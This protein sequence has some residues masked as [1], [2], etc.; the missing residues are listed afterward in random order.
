[1]VSIVGL[2]PPFVVKKIL[3][4]KSLR[5]RKSKKR[6]LRDKRSQSTVIIYV[7]EIHAPLA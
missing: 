2:E 6:L 3:F 4:L 7:V 5:K 1:M